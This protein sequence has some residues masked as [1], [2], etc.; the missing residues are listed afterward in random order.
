M[1]TVVQI[2]PSQVLNLALI[3]KTQKSHLRHFDNSGCLTENN[4][5]QYPYPPS[6]TAILSHDIDVGDHPLIKKHAYC[7]N[8]AKHALLQ[9]EFTYL[10]E[11]GLAYPQLQCVEH[12]MS[13]PAQTR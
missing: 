9:L 6:C 11:N 3:S 8:P 4:L 7:V 12:S 1:S 10:L 5:P 2:S 13:A